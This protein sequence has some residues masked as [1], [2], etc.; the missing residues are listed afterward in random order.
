M[1]STIFL[2]FLVFVG[3]VGA[4]AV[5]KSRKDSRRTSIGFFLGNR[6]LGFW[7]IGCSLFLTNMSANQFIG[8][9]E[10]VYTTNMSVMAWGMSSV[11]AMVLVAEFLMPVYLRIG[12]VTTPDF[13]ELRFDRQTK[14]MVS[15]IFL[16]SYIINLVP[17]VMY[18]CAVAINGIFHIDQQ[19]G[20]SYFTAVRLLVC[21]IGL[22]G[23]LYT[24]LGGLKAIVI[25][26]T[27]QGVGMLV[28]AIL[29][30]WFGFRRLGNGHLFA[31]LG[32]LLRTHTDHLN[33][34]GGPHDAVPLGTLF[35]GMLL[36]NLYYWGMEQYIVQEALAS[37]SLA[38]GQKGIALACVGKL[39][40]P[41]LL[42]VPGLIAVHLYAH[43]DNTA[44]VFPRLVSDILP[45]VLAGFIAAIVFGGALS[46][47]NA[48][49]N[50]LGTLWVMNIYKPWLG[51]RKGQAGDRQL[52]WAGKG[53]Q[54]VV[55][56]A[57]V[58]FSPYIMFV[59]GGFYNYLQKVSS[60][61]SVPV[62]TVMV[63][64]MV[65]RK[66]PPIA[67]KVGLLFF[68]VAYILTQFVFDTGLHYL[69]VLALLFGATVILMLVIGYWLP[70]ETP[71]TRRST[72]V[73]PLRPWKNR[74]WYFGILLL[75]M[76]GLFILFSPLGIAH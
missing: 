32:E 37:N 48:G 39:G 43:M 67:A 68:I 56:G 16:L 71:Y 40:A 21:F 49:I 6:S 25:S 42:N 54:V 38:A 12:A 29:I 53:F 4:L 60:F 13:L 72:A 8:E 50:S 10:F 52:L 65:T 1:N 30:A 61:F 26:D 41:L 58:A 7:M 5:Y 55:I 63:V 31:G 44:A 74:W 27:I 20:V 57:A 24:V 11:A 14:A 35:T 69:H 9:N 59:H 73:V 51:R 64:G 66:V 76:I 22:I 15:I 46:T 18:G 2:S 17:S 28:G 19:L 36:I 62:F 45:P 33:A 34:I 75:L 47:F 3:C 70:L 23:G